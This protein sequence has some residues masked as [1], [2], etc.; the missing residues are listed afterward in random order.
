MT[1]TRVMI[2]RSVM[3]LRSVSLTLTMSLILMRRRMAMQKETPPE[4]C[5]RKKASKIYIVF[6]H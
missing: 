4:I 6:Y 3:R 1:T 5:L 2:H